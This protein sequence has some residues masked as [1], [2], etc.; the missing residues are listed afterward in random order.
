MTDNRT[1]W[2]GLQEPNGGGKLVTSAIGVCRWS[3][4]LDQPAFS[5]PRS[6][7]VCVRDLRNPDSLKAASVGADVIISTVSAI[8]RAKVGDSFATTDSAG[9]I[10]LID[11]AAAAGAKQFI[12]VS[13]DGNGMPDALEARWNAAGDPFSRSF[14][15][16]MLGVARGAAAECELREEFPIRMTT[17]GEFA[18]GLRARV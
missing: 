5:D 14:A 3:S 16:L 13:F 6:A 12:F 11:A 15:A 2:R 10:N 7:D 8:G 1:P 9:N 18:H 4:S 17:V